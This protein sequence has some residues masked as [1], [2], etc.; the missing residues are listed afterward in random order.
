MAEEITFMDLAALTKITTNT[1]LEK[2]GSAL[3]S[4]IFDASNIAGSLKQKGLIEF[5][6]YYPGPNT[7]TVT[8]SG[9]SL[10]SEADAKS[11]EA[12]DDLDEGILKQL[13]GG[14]RIPAELQN[15]LN[16]R[17]KDLAMR[18]Y[19]LTKQGYI[20]YEL[21]NG[22]AEIMLTEKGFLSSKTATQPQAVKPN[23]QQPPSA[24]P[25]SIPM[26]Q[27]Q[28]NQQPT[29]TTQTPQPSTQTPTQQTIPYVPSHNNKKNGII[30]AMIIVIVVVF[31]LYYF[32]VLSKVF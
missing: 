1:Q 3:N 19:K 11:S 18:L 5:T 32:N 15:T 21:K 16:L 13:S 25:Q 30:V 28:P 29:A 6:A 17:P 20:V 24:T 27:Q 9:K 8:D 31:L 7:I 14:K 4:S 12:F 23:I 10:I 22:G 2:L 26:Q